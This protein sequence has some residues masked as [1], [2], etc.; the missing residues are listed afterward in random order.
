MLQF[1]YDFMDKYLNQSSYK[2]NEADTDSLYLSLAGNSVEA[3]ISQ[4]KIQAFEAEKHL[5]FVTPQAPQGK[6][7]PEC[8]KLNILVLKSYLCVPRAT[9]SRILTMGLLSSQ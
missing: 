1:Y 8:S 6:R 2:I 5:W 9:A 4:E 3:L 7:A